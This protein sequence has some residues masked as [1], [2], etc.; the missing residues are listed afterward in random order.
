MYFHSWSEPIEK[1]FVLMV[2]RFQ[3]VKITKDRKLFLLLALQ[4]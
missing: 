1:E 4:Y 3:M 2:D